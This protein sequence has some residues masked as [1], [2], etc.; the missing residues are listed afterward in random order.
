MEMDVSERTG[1]GSSDRRIGLLASTDVIKPITLI[2]YLMKTSARQN[3][4]SQRI[5]FDAFLA[6]LETG[7]AVGI[8][9]LPLALCVVPSRR[10]NRPRRKSGKSNANEVGLPL[11]KE[12]ARV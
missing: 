12:E 6:S 3:R 11:Q 8:A 5:S 1:C 4:L 9:A 2:K 10:M 7:F